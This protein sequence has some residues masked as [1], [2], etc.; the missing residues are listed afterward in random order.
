TDFSRWLFL[1]ISLSTWISLSISK[2]LRIVCYYTNWSVY[3][4]GV[5]KFT[6][7]NINP[8]LCTHLIYAF[9]GFTKENTLKPFDKYQDIEK[10]GYAKF[11]GLKTY[12]KNLK[13][14]LAIGGWNEGSARFS[15]MVASPE[16]RKQF[17]RNA[18]K[19]LRQNHFDG[20]DL[21]W[22]Y[23]AFRDGGKPRD[24]E[25]YA[26]LVQELREEFD[27]ES[28][29]TG[30]PRLLL[31]MAVPAGIE[32]VNKGY[33]I[34]KLMKYLDWMNMLSYDFHSAYEPAVNH[35][36]PLF[37]LEEANEYSFDAELNIDYTIQHYIKLGADPSKLV[38]GIPTYGRSYTLYNPEAHDIES[39]ADG[40]GSMGEYTREN[41]YLA[42]YEICEYIKNDGWEV[43]QVNPKAMGPYSHKDNQWVGYDDI[44]MVRKKAEYVVE[45][46]LGGIM[47]WAIDN[48]DFRGT[49][50]GKAYPLIEAAKEAMIN[51]LGLSNEN[52]IAPPS[53][54]IKSKTRSRP[55]TSTTE[56]VIYVQP[57]KEVKVETTATRRRN[58][59]KTKSKESSSKEIVKPRRNIAKPEQKPEPKSEES[60]TYSSLIV[61]PSYTT[62]EPPSTP[63]MAGGFKCEDEG[64]YP[65]P[66]DCKKY[67]WCLNGAG[68][69][70]IVAHQFTCPA[71]LYFNKAADSCDYSQNVLCNKK[72]QKSSATTTKATTTTSAP[73]STTSG[74]LPTSIFATSRAPPRI[75]PI[76]RP[77]TT[78]TTTTTEAYKDDEEDYEE[79]EE[80]D[81]KTGKVEPEEDPKVIKEL[82]ELIKKAGGIEELEKQLNRSSESSSSSGT[83]GS[84][85]Q[86]SISKSLY[87]RV[88][89]KAGRPSFKTKKNSDRPSYTSIRNSSGPQSEATEAKATSSR[90]KSDR[91]K[92]QYTSIAR[93]RPSTTKAPDVDDEENE[94]DDV[95]ADA[96]VDIDEDPS[97]DEEEESSS[98]SRKSYFKPN[99]VNIRRPRVSSTTESEVDSYFNRNKILGEIL[100]DDID[101]DDVDVDLDEY[102]ENR[103]R[104][105]ST[106]QYVNIRRQ[107]PSTTEGPSTSKYVE[108]RRSTTESASTSSEGDSE[109]TT[110]KYHTIRR[111]TTTP[112]TST[113]EDT[114][115]S[116]QGR[117]GTSTSVITTIGTTE[118][119]TKKYTSVNRESS[120]KPTN[121]DGIAKSQTA[122]LASET[123]EI[124]AV[125]AN[126]EQ[127]AGSTASIGTTTP[128][129][130]N[131]DSI[132]DIITTE[133]VPSTK[134]KTI[135][136]STTPQQPTT[137]IT[138]FTS[139]TEETTTQTK[140]PIIRSTTIKPVSESSPKVS[141]KNYKF[142]LRA[143]PEV[144][145]QASTSAP[146]RTRGVSRFSTKSSGGDSSEISATL[147]SARRRLISTTEKVFDENRSYRPGDP[148]LADLS[149]LTA[150]DTDKIRGLSLGDNTRRRRIRPTNSAVTTESPKS[151][152][153]PVRRNENGGEQNTAVAGAK[154]RGFRNRQP[155]STENTIS[156]V[157]KGISPSTKSLFTSRTR[158]IIR[159][160]RPTTKAGIF[161]TAKSTTK[162][163]SFDE[164]SFDPDLEF[165]FQDNKV[166]DDSDEGFE[167]S[168]LE[169]DENI[170]LSESNIREN[171]EINSFIGK[172][173]VKSFGKNDDF[174]GKDDSFGRKVKGTT[175]RSK[176]PARK[177]IKRPSSTTTTTTKAPTTTSNRRR[178]IIRRV[179]PVIK[180]N[181]VPVSKTKNATSKVDE[182][183]FR[184]HLFQPQ[185]HIAKP[186]V[187]DETGEYGLKDDIEEYV[188]KTVISKDHGHKE[189]VED[190]GQ[191]SSPKEDEHSD[192]KSKT[193]KLEEKEKSV[194]ITVI[195][196]TL[197]ESDD[198]DVDDSTTT[199]IP[200]TT[201]RSS[202]FVTD[203][204]PNES[205]Q[206]PKSAKSTTSEDDKNN[207]YKTFTRSRTTKE[208]I[209]TFT[210]DS[211]D[212]EEE[213]DN[214]DD[215]GFNEDEEEI[216]FGPDKTPKRKTT[217]VLKTTQVTSLDTHTIPPS[218][219]T[220]AT[221]NSTTVEEPSATETIPI[222][223]TT[224]RD[225]TSIMDNFKTTKDTENYVSE[226]IDTST[227]SMFTDS[228]LAP[229]NDSDPD[230]SSPPF[231]IITDLSD[232]STSAADATQSLDITTTTTQ[233]TTTTYKPRSSLR[234]VDARPRFNPRNL[235]KLSGI[236]RAPSTTESVL[237]K[238]VSR[239]FSTTER[240]KPDKRRKLFR[241]R[242]TTPDPIENSKASEGIPI[243]QN[244]YRVYKFSTTKLTDENH[245]E[246]TAEDI[247]KETDRDLDH[248]MEDL[249]DNYGHD[250]ETSSQRSE[251]ITEK[252]INR[253]FIPGKPLVK[254][255]NVPKFTKSTETPNTIS[256]LNGVDTEAIRN[257]N[258]NLFSRRFK[259][260]IPG[261]DV[262]ATTETH[263]LTTEYAEASTEP[264]FDRSETTEMFTTLH[265]VFAQEFDKSTTEMEVKP[266]TTT[267]KI[268]R[269]VEVNRIVK[270][271]TKE[272]TVKN[273]VVGEQKTNE[274][275]PV[276]DKIGEVNRV[277][278]IKVVDKDGNVGNDPTFTEA[279][280]E[281][282]PFEEVAKIEEVPARVEPVNLTN[283]SVR[284]N[285]IGDS[286]DDRK[287]DY[288]PGSIFNKYVNYGK[289]DS[290]SNMNI[291]TPRPVYHTEASTI[292]LEGLFSKT[293]APNLF[294]SKKSALSDEILETDN[295]KFVN[296]RVL[297]PND[298]K[299]EKDVRDE[300][301]FIPI[302]LLKQDDEDFTVK[303]QIKEVTP[304]QGMIKIVPIRVAMS[305]AIFSRPKALQ[306]DRSPT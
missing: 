163:S 104:N 180:Y 130:L 285:G 198:T 291:F 85:T 140:R 65:H 31:T 185:T 176:P 300:R 38:L 80:I 135:S 174:F 239:R 90:G 192:N 210:F 9:G 25:N 120:E 106:P 157:T 51:A 19:F 199:E 2:E 221:E 213:F 71:G 43:E 267:N 64:F 207:K 146:Q 78:T 212:P 215:E 225:I 294:N 226:H 27:R 292:A 247:Q 290:F 175:E 200:S 177:I 32:Y 28:E 187:K 193:T 241:Q 232:S 8:Y 273:H 287:I 269:L 275:V 33:D 249:G 238:E 91:G 260:A 268:E 125:S 167:D 59:F 201:V 81:S 116:T 271:N 295:S 277:T 298:M 127:Q 276:L 182:K 30:R 14:M 293:E 144:G 299:L 302:K 301:R 57:E 274:V 72:L 148:E 66:K 266:E 216:G 172:E 154:V 229:I 166:E 155:T 115:T 169:D 202:T 195:R 131:T 77:T 161:T 173:R 16:R 22:E 257:R 220:T 29:K 224:D 265:H 119:T 126:P 17:V 109:G 128:Y 236:N 74:R 100:E 46:G 151:T 255:V 251:S 281:Q 142:R 41:G 67:Y 5:A 289:D 139:S 87:E 211:S 24:K 191:K 217:K 40:P 253:P 138:R 92:L 283:I 95:D 34:P 121:T 76:T 26:A 37:P 88:L 42:Y 170:K 11:T 168:S 186:A 117:R 252:I 47:F 132:N 189:D 114:S 178:K 58:R 55:T 156:K 21:D 13:T 134:T 206:T 288:Y 4:P 18:L 20:L 10:G 49:C 1:L 112:A 188:Q 181:K 63:D 227:I 94:D 149:S 286:R 218:D 152:R 279:K 133:V 110:S 264:S 305:R 150:V 259:G 254:P 179:R 105:P 296:V 256:E 102:G 159:R 89:S 160:V 162:K 124:T 205:S 107:R 12:N 86:S 7:Q 68:D 204:L 306:K 39:P 69:S 237:E 235:N 83:S 250:D 75:S 48:D 36:A 153:R 15:P 99:Y 129:N 303:A 214:D 103:N 44:D 171:S 82:I 197:V 208:T 141:H 122:G 6:P 231:D 45:R 35:H 240:S 158:K 230:L 184:Q 262:S 242:S 137:R 53:K 234:P 101:L 113:E 243:K 219:T 3:R 50:H 147:P 258:K 62:P 263:F 246:K 248:A 190:G 196:S 143:K 244:K 280:V 164:S 282:V 96:D 84:T 165:G 145:E 111:G 304:K 97:E 228:T 56:R 98:K 118:G 108:I 233:R 93:N 136:T 194:N 278:V 52:L 261:E 70:G 79:D 54:P 209:Y 245:N 223:S 284:I 123:G 222:T 61:T 60:S 270:V 73:V 183:A 23:P 203:S 272:A 297:K